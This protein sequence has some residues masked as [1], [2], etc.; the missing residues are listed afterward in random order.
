MIE[1]LKRL[2]EEPS[3]EN[4]SRVN[5]EMYRAQD[6]LVNYHFLLSQ[7]TKDDKIPDSPEILKI[8]RQIEN[9]ELLIKECREVAAKIEEALKAKK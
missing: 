1:Y 4:L 9:E 5:H 2:G 3:H 8:R 7:I 6:I